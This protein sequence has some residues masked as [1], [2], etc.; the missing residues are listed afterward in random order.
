MVDRIYK[1]ADE[2]N[3]DNA[4]ARTAS[5]K[6]NTFY[7]AQGTS[8]G[9]IRFKDLNGDGVINSADQQVIGSAQPKFFGGF[10]NQFSYKGI[11]LGFFFQY[12]YG[13]QILNVT[14]EYAEGMNSQFGQLATTLNRWTPNNTN[15]DMPRAAAG[16]PNGNTRNSTRFVED[17]SYL[18]LKT[19][20][21]GY[22]LPKP[23]SEAIHFQNIR[24]YLSGQ[25]LLTFTKYSG[26]D[27]EVSTFSG[28]NTSLGTDF[29]TF[30]QARTYQVGV[31]LSL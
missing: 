30:P 21:L 20:T 8:A 26:L 24:V 16:D 4:A 7:Q 10:N 5:G 6:S 3:V 27:P 23:W 22:N 25:N 2:V 28:T 11:D 13:N 29:L 31:N 15:T 1:S 17:G 19:A 12:T 18:R 14:R 9:D